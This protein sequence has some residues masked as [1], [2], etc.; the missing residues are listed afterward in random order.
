MVS[1]YLCYQ[2]NFQ[3]TYIIIVFC[4]GMWLKNTYLDDGSLSILSNI[5]VWR[6]RVERKL[7]EM[8]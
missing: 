6:G 4:L 1:Q 7:R 5:K 2:R 3:E 8:R